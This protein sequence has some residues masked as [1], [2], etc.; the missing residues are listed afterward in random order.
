MAFQRR[1]RPPHKRAD[2]IVVTRSYRW[3]FIM[4]LDK[5][6]DSIDQ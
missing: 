4:R 3:G 6:T 5:A 2:E 1:S